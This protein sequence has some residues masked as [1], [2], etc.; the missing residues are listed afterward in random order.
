MLVAAGSVLLGILLT[1]A[2][3]SVARTAYGLQWTLIA[4]SAVLFVLLVIPVAPIGVNRRHPGRLNA[5]C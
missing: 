5:D 2:R 3:H 4:L 1:N